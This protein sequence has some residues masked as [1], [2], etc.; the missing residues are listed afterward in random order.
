[1]EDMKIR[2]KFALQLKGFVFFNGFHEH[3][4]YSTDF[5]N[6]RKYGQRKSANISHRT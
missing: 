4:V 3:I 6:K 2:C 5:W 1:M